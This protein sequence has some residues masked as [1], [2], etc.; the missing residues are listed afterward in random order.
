MPIKSMRVRK[1]DVPYMTAEWKMAIRR[2]RRS[3]K[4]YNKNKTE[5]NWEIMKAWRNKATRLRRIA[6]RDYWRQPSAE[7]KRDPK[8]FCRTFMPFLN[9]KKLKDK[10]EITLNIQGTLLQDQ[11]SV[12]EEFADYFATV[13]ESSFDNS[14]AMNFTQKNANDTQASSPYVVDGTLIRLPSGRSRKRKLF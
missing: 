10:T 8:K 4:R 9:N 7:S 3:A 11:R 13:G 14:P 1:R 5:E 6:I 12:A 2:K